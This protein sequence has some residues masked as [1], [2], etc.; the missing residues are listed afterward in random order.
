[1]KGAVQAPCVPLVNQTFSGST[2]VLGDVCILRMLSEHDALL[3]VYVYHVY[4]YTC[5]PCIHYIYMYMYT[6]YMWVGVVDR[7]KA[8]ISE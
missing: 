4:N 1:M 2:L 3:C 7:P 8:D 5:I 6:M